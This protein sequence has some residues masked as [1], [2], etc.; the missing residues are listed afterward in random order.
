M[1]T[2]KGILIAGAPVLV[3][4]F[5]CLVMIAF[6]NRGTLPPEGAQWLGAF[7][8]IVGA[9]WTAYVVFGPLFKRKNPNS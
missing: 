6:G 4:I 1:E 2:F 3:I 7:I 8:A 9:L 5:G